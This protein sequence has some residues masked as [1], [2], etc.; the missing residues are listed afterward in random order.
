[1]AGT[2]ITKHNF[3][4]NDA[5]LTSLVADLTAAG[6]TKVYPV[7]TY[8]PNTSPLV[9]LQATPTIDSL[10][11]AQP[12]R[13]AL[14][15]RGATGD[16]AQCV[17]L[18]LGTP[19]TISDTG[20]LATVYQSVSTQTDTQPVGIIGS[21]YAA[22]TISKT[23][24]THRSKVFWSRADRDSATGTD[25]ANPFSY[26]LTTT[27]RGIALHIWEPGNVLGKDNQGPISSTV[28]IQRLVDNATGATLVTGKAPLHCLYCIHNQF[29]RMVVREQDILSPGP[30]IYADARTVIN[31]S[32]PASGAGADITATGVDTLDQSGFGTQN[33]SAKI[34]TTPAGGL[35]PP[36]IDNRSYLAITEDNN[37]VTTFPSGFT[38]SR[39]AYYGEMDLIAYTSADIV[40]QNAIIQFTAYGES[41]PR[42]YQALTA[43]G[44]DSTKVRILQ[45]IDGGDTALVS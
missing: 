33:S 18:I 29:Y 4:T 31:L 10:A 35:F 38:T 8:N 27:G 9:V 26:K 17:D 13:I 28:V 19:N 43:T 16:A 3:V 36:I 22:D 42:K 23:S 40:A 21:A 41:T 34:T 2:S 32:A 11:E 7:D 5:F 12:W 45:L 44:P 30:S 1:M 20:V 24:L 6:F 14:R 37:Y 15:K 25:V 39:Y